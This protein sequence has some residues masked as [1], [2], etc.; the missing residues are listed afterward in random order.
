MCYWKFVYQFNKGRGGLSLEGGT[1]IWGG[2][3]GVGGGGGLMRGVTFWGGA[4]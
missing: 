3:L 2:S 1:L 4:N